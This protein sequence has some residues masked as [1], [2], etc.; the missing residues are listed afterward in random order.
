[1]RLRAADRIHVEV[2]RA[3]SVHE[4]WTARRLGGPQHLFP[5][6][7]ARNPQKVSKQACLN[8]RPPCFANCVF[9][10]SDFANSL[11][12]RLQQNFGW[13]LPCPHVLSARCCPVLAESQ[14]YEIYIPVYT[15]LQ[16]DN[17]FSSTR[18]PQYMDGQGATQKGLHTCL[19]ETCG[20][21]DDS[22]P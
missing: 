5:A 9:A 2:L 12:C 8:R 11:H 7:L 17:T 16:H 13:L 14:L 18:Q 3:A 6:K 21:K 22:E 4:S 10:S 20:G 1:M 19:L 15:S